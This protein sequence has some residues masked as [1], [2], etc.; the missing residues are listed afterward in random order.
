[1]LR[2]SK[3]SRMNIENGKKQ[4]PKRWYIKREIRAMHFPK[5][6]QSEMKATEY[7]KKSIPRYQGQQ[8]KGTETKKLY[9]G[10][11]A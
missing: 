11:E 10:A 4:Q 6:S 5:M 3:T 7:L 9:K 8:E 1:M 2:E